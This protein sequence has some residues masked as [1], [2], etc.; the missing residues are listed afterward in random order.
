MFDIAHCV[1]PVKVTVG[2]LNFLHL[3]QYKMSD[4]ITK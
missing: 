2:I 1:I 3:E 4:P